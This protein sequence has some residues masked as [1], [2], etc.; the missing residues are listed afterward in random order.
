MRPSFL[1]LMGVLFVLPL[2]LAIEDGLA[3]SPQS[4]AL[5]EMI[6]YY[7]QGE[8]DLLTKDGELYLKVTN[9][10]GIHKAKNSLSPITSMATFPT[11]KSISLVNAAIIGATASVLCLAVYALLTLLGHS[12]KEQS[13]KSAN[14]V[15]SHHHHHDRIFRKTMNVLT[16]ANHAANFLDHQRAKAAHRVVGLNYHRFFEMPKSH[17]AAITQKHKELDQKLAL[18]A[19]LVEKHQHQESQNLEGYRGSIA[20][21]AE[22]YEAIMESDPQIRGTPLSFH[23]QNAIEEYFQAQK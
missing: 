11:L 18:Y 12:A 20:K 8:I 2:T 13:Q 21:I 17:L 23:A 6:H 16:K 22:N 19:A 5:L 4:Q 14:P 7:E 3:H 15:H 9:L 10:T 1:L